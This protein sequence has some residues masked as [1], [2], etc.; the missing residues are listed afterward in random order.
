MK[1]FVIA[2]DMS[3]MPPSSQTFIRQR[4][5]LATDGDEKAEKHLVNLIHFRFVGGVF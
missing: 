5:F 2:Y 4:T 1:V 3:D